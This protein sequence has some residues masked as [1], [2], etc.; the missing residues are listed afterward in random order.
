[1]PKISKY[2]GLYIM[3]ETKNGKTSTLGSSWNKA[4][5][6]EIKE[7]KRM[8]CPVCGNEV[9]SNKGWAAKFYDG[10]CNS[11]DIPIED[12]DVEEVTASDC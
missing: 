12:A 3:T 6:E 11:C 8:I 9:R 4:D 5:L 2:K 7:D 10:Y 1:M